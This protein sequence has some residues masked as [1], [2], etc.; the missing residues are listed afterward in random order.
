ISKA[1]WNEYYADVLGGKD[2]ILLGIYSHMIDY[3]LYL[4]NYPMGHLIDFQIE[5]QVRDKN[6]SAEIERMYTQG[7]IIPQLWMKNAVGSPISI[8]PL[9]N[10]TKRALEVLNK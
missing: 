2:E 6:L 8:E 1:V 4:P 10:K 3:P 9:L 5:Q 7:S